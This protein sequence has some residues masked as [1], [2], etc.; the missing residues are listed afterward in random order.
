MLRLSGV[1][2]KGAPEI[3]TCKPNPK[4]SAASKPA[5]VSKTFLGETASKKTGYEKEGDEDEAEELGPEAL[6]NELDAL[7]FGDSDEDLS[8]DKFDL[9]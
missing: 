2:R 8:D 9:R 7:D 4:P 1:A 5:V 6:Q 3:D